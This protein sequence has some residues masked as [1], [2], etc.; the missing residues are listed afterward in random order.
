MDNKLKNYLIKLGF[1]N[2]EIKRFCSQQPGLEMI[3]AERAFKNIAT[4]VSFGYPKIDIDGLIF[5]NPGFLCNDPTELLNL[6][7]SLNG[8]VEEL[9]KADPFLI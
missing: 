2:D 3:A 4:V 7:Q 1:S 8:N 6:L 9:L 5:S